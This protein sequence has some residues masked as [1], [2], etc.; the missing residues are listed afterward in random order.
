MALAYRVTRRG[1]RLGSRPRIAERVVERYRGEA[2][3]VG[4]A[5]IGDDPSSRERGQTTFGV[6]DPDRELGA[7]PIRLGRRQDLR[8]G[9]VRPHESLEEPGQASRLVA[10]RCN[11]HLV[12]ALE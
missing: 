12:E 6:R 5:V 10:Q 4:L 8:L 3:D 2:D 9:D 7:T 11:A 1:Q